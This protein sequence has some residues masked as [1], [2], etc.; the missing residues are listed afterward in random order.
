MVDR[1]RVREVYAEAAAL[2]GAER[3][4]YLNRECA[5]DAALRAEV[6]SL[7][8]AAERRPEFLAEPTVGGG[9]ASTGAGREALGSRIGPY[10]LLEEIGQGGFGSVYMA[11][12]ETPVRRRVA[13]KIIK[14]GMDTRAVIARF[15]AER[16][17]LAMMDH[18]HIARV[19]DAGAT[20]A[21]RPYFVM[22]LVQGEP[23]TAYADR[24][25][26]SISER[27]E[28][29][30]Q[31]CQAVQHAHTK[32]VIHRD[33]KPGNVLVAAQDGR[34][35][36]KVIDF[37]IA[38]ATDHRLTEKTVFTEFRQLIGTPEYMSPEQAGGAP[39][40]DTRS[41]VYSL[42]VLLYELLTGATPFDARELR[43]AAYGE[44]QRIIREVEPPKPSTKLS[45]MAALASVAAVRGT[46]PA[47]LG[48]IV[49]GDLD[50]IVMRCL[51]K[52]RGRRYDTAEALAAD[53]GR[54]LGGEP[55]MAAPPSAAYRMRKFI[56]RHRAATLAGALVA[57]TLLLGVAGTSLG[58]LQAIRARGEAVENARQAAANAEQ[59]GKE[60]KRADAQAVEALTSARVAEGV[61]ELMATMIGRADRAREQG[62]T[63]VTV[64]EV[65]DAAA[66]DL[67][68]GVAT[69]EPRV[70]SMLARTIGATYGQLNLLEPAER[71][72][73]LH[74]RLTGEVFGER[75]V[76][77]A[78]SALALADLLRK[79]GSVDEARG[80]YASARSIAAEVGDGAIEIGAGCVVGEAELDYRLGNAS[81]AEADLRGVLKLLE[82]KGLAGSPAAITATNNLAA[83]LWASGKRKEA[84]EVYEH[85]LRL[86][87]ERGVEPD[88]VEM[89]SNL[90]AVQHS[91]RDFEGA[92]RTSAEQ[93]AL[94][95]GLYGGRHLTLA[96]ALDSYAMILMAR[97]KPDEAIAAGR[98]VVEIRRAL[99]KPG[100][101][102]LAASLRK[103][104]GVLIDA[105]RYEE[106]E[107][108]LR[109]ACE[110]A[111][112][113]VPPGEPDYV[114]ARYQHAVALSHGGANA[115]A[116]SILRRVM[117]DSETTLKE[118]SRLWWMR[119]ASGCLLAG[120]VAAGAEGADEVERLRRL[121]ESVALI[122]TFAERLLGVKEGM[123]Q[124]TRRVVVGRSL[125]QVVRA[126][127]V[128]ARL[129]P[130]AEREHA[131]THWKGRREAFL[132]EVGGTR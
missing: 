69:R 83:M 22:E 123:G 107:P 46:A 63:D 130:S 62:R 56:S 6:D 51:E 116:E 42:G 81:K 75:A 121:E 43:S 61:N 125:D 78:S 58:L 50:W 132:A 109:E 93:V 88:R 95:R 8:L 33:I 108:V 120:V 40:V 122:G 106:A 15:E 28:L 98:E 47:R 59:A 19:F 96:R 10:K 5:G 84:Q 90:A 74:H 11:E 23:I 21:G 114:F 68:A 124:R 82:S 38:K 41:D 70:A 1:G 119:G 110:S 117:V 57:G 37:G 99:L 80:L 44:V 55:V 102:S 25:S 65:M 115:E 113:L 85:S 29:F 86:L 2:A 17:A 60:A 111:A 39:D 89:L 36:A 24:A 129:A 67:E 32:G 52:D 112:R 45:R 87:R 131:L 20:E 48:A 76:E 7:L 53:I 64:R 27:L 14:L 26:L 101:E 104:G 35:H 4:A 66:A 12:Q 73:R 30:V 34:P 118:G 128:A 92:E 94:V 126:C 18:P 16:Q 54:H 71:M 79:R 91:Q 103:L 105:E 13:L 127:E 3:A 72:L 9:P 49:R 100:H 31:V 77:R 97:E